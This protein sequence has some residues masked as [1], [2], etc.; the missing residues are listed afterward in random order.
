VPFRFTHQFDE[1][2]ALASALATK[3]AHDFFQALAQ[4][5]CLLTDDLGRRRAL[6]RDRLDEAQEFF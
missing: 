4:L 6:A 3:A 2:V 1:D 5:L